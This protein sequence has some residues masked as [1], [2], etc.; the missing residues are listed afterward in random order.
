MAAVQTHEDSLQYTDIISQDGGVT[1]LFDVAQRNE[2]RSLELYVVPVSYNYNLASWLGVGAGVQFR[3]RLRETTTVNAMHYNYLYYE[4]QNVQEPRRENDYASR[5]ESARGF[6]N[7]S[8]AFFWWP[9]A[10][11][12]THRPCAGCAVRI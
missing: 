9:Y 7:L 1:N 5:D 11:Q 8:P 3:L 2:Y 12:R 6:G 10:G 4:K